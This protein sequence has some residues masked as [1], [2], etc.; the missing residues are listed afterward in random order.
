MG[1]RELVY[2]FLLYGIACLPPGFLVAQTSY[3]PQYFSPNTGNPGQV[4]LQQDYDQAGWVTITSG[5]QSVNSWSAPQAL[6]FAFS[7]FGQAVTYFKVSQNGL[8]T[9]DTATS[10]LPFKNNTNLPSDSLPPK[11]IACFWDA[12]TSAPPTGNNDVV[13]IQTFGFAPNRQFWIRW[14]SFE[15]GNP[16]ADFN[17]FACILSES[18]NKILVLDMGYHALAQNLSSTVG[19]QLDDSTAVQYGD[20][21]LGL[22]TGTSTNVDNVWYEFAPYTP[23]PVNLTV[24]KLV[25]PQSGCGLGSSEPVSIQIQNLG[26]DTIFSIPV[27]YLVNGSGGGCDTVF[28]TIA[29]LDF[30]IVLF[31]VPGSFSATGNHTVSAWTFAPLDSDQS[32]DTL[33]TTISNSAPVSI[34]PYLETFDS[35]TKDLFEPVPLSG[36]WVNV[37][38]EGP[39]D[40]WINDG[41]TPT[42]VTGPPADHT[43]GSGKYL[44]MEDSNN[45]NDSIDLVTP[46]FDLTGVTVGMGFWVHSKETNGG[47]FNVNELYVQ[48]WDGNSYSDLDTIGHIGPAWVFMQYDLAAYSNLIVHFRLRGNDNNLSIFHDIAIDDFEV[49]E[50]VPDNVSV[51]GFVS[52]LNSSCGLGSEQVCIY[53]TNTGSSSTSGSFPVTYAVGSDTVTETFASILN[54]QDTVVHCFSTPANLN[55]IANYIVTAWTS[56]PADTIFSDD[57]SALSLSK[58]PAINSFPYIEDF[59]SGNGYWESQGL[60]NSWAYGNPAKQVISGAASG[61]YAW[62][63]GGSSGKYSNMENSWVVG[64]CFDFTGLVNPWFQAKVWWSCEAGFDAAALQY[65]PDTGKTWQH[66]GQAGDPNAWYTQS[67]VNSMNV[68]TGNGNGWTGGKTGNTGSGGWTCVNHACTA[69]AGQSL[70][71][72][73]FV[74]ASDGTFNDDGFAFDD[75][76]ITEGPPIAI[77][78]GPDTALCDTQYLLSSG[79]TVGNFLW[80][81]G[82]VTPALQVDTTGNYWLNSIGN[83]GLCAYDTASILI[84]GLPVVDIGPDTTICGGDTV[85]LDAKNT[86]EAILWSTGDTTQTIKVDTTGTYAVT[87]ING[88]NCQVTDSV[89]I[90]RLDTVLANLGPDTALCGNYHIL[91]AGIPLQKYIWNTGDTTQKIYAMASGN[92]HVWINSLCGSGSDTIDLILYPLP[93]VNLGPDQTACDS[94]VLTAGNPGINLLWFNGDTVQSVTVLQTGAYWLEVTDTNG[95]ANSDT[96]FL[97]IQKVPVAGIASDT[98]ACPTIGFSEVQAGGQSSS[99]LWDFGDGGSSALQNPTHTYGNNGVYNVTLTAQNACGSDIGSKVETISCIIG[100]DHRVATFSIEIYPVPASTLLSIRIP[101][102]LPG[103]ENA[104]TITVSDIFGRRAIQGKALPSDLN[105]GTNLDVSNLPGGIYLLLLEA[106][107]SR[108][109]GKFEIIH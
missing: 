60:Q 47:T 5:N 1:L 78:I 108:Y 26:T 92:Y 6:P 20:S 41:P 58:M 17:Y 70:V 45:D 59:E 49:W 95:C 40:W 93:N 19:L 7:F 96:I 85:T 23:A 18:S 33:N 2:R 107:E 75:I 86:E 102:E 79:L 3:F 14:F 50:K 68:F 54:P 72:F 56:Y 109:Q 12:F 106:G 101:G 76:M 51:A 82:D 62:M 27:C 15:M 74:F 67:A 37:T 105:V 55:S 28:V 16:V 25:K 8:I 53:V 34:F 63:T 4:N 48:I 77:S 104:M 38:G 46:C 22:I 42:A 100:I 84:L 81:T 61:L 43:S 99:W 98:S 13:D 39:Q 90:I 71:Q 64:P 73:R 57:S 66:L 87:V 65:S 83:N 91:D 97:F 24:T 21:I 88:N 30:A 52:P 35:W 94:F 29:P 80:S 10:V 36:G 89:F 69:L 31:A 103:N 9:F 32:N 11:T 44:Y